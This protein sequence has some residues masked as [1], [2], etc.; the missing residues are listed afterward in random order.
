MKCRVCGVSTPWRREVQSCLW[1]KQGADLEE[2][3]LQERLAGAPRG[4]WV[5]RSERM[6][7]QGSQS[8]QRQP[9]STSCFG[10]C[11]PGWWV[12][13]FILFR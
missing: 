6:W 1:E 11:V 8:R 10:Q 12:R 7:V 5:E 2:R 13:Y 9:V 3:Q 4:M